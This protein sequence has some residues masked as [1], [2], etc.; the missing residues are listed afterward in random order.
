MCGQVKVICKHCGERGIITKTDRQTVDY[1]R[2]YCTCKNPACGHSWVADIQFSHT[3]QESK[4]TKDGIINY[5]LNN[6]PSDTLATLKLSI[7]KI[8][9]E[10]KQLNFF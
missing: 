4:I 6:L 3:L 10:Q 7:E 5:L 2:L 9:T 1:S 8:Q